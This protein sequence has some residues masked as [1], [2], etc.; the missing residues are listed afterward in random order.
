MT[1]P[2]GGMVFFTKWSL[3]SISSAVGWGGSCVL[4]KRVQWTLWTSWTV[5]TALLIDAQGEILWRG[6]PDSAD[7]VALIADAIAQAE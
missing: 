5:W 7:V 4:A 6:N 1:A 2:Y 3:F